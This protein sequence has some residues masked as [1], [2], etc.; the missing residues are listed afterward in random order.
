MDRLDSV[1]PPENATAIQTVDSRE[2]TGLSEYCIF[3]VKFVH[4][5][6]IPNR[7]V[8]TITHVHALGSL[9]NKR[10]T[11]LYNSR[12]YCSCGPFGGLAVQMAC[13]Y[14]SQCHLFWLSEKSNNRQHRNVML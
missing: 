4:E 2:E 11:V 10:G 7:L 13:P 12:L 6:Q 5:S 3:I 9:A 14:L 1:I 8:P